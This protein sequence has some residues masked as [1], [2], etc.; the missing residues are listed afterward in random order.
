MFETHHL[1]AFLAASV[2]LWLTP[3]PDTMYILARASFGLRLHRA[4][5]ESFAFGAQPA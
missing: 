4:R 3:G 2:L 1:W 5:S